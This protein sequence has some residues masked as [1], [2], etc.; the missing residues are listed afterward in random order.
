M[1]LFLQ[2]LLLLILS[3]SFAQPTGHQRLFLHIT[4]KA[5]TI[6]FEKCFENT[7]S[8]NQKTLDYKGYQ[9]NDISSNPTGFRYYPASGFIHK[10]FMD[11]N[12]RIQI[13]RHKTDTMNIEILNAFK[14]Y[15]L[16]IAFRPGNFR[17]AVNDGK[18]HSW[19][20]NTLPYKKLGTDEN[21][22]NITPPDWSVFSIASYKSY[23]DYFISLE[24]EK[25]RI[26]AKPI[27]P[28]DDPNFRNPRRINNLK[29]ETE[30]YNFDGQ[31]DYREQ[32]V[33]DLTSWN[34]FIY[35]GTEKGFVLDTL[36][37]SLEYCTFDFE[38]K[39][40]SGSKTTRVNPELTQTDSYKYLDGKL[41]LVSQLI[42]VHAF[43]HSEKKD[44][45]VFVLENGVMVFKELIHGAE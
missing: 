22:Y 27:I 26:L 7:A 12:H 25:Q 23:L 1:K 40:F 38:K 43:P 11:R 45:S 4:D 33:K 41:T 8:V 3:P 34:Y 10:T 2:I 35:T 42:C 32:K 37:S 14:V 29:I 6:H 24:F 28:E 39:T 13:V 44:C 36:L 17:L 18:E 20:Y 16:H 30:D 19:L 9:L 5:D 15:F 21:I 31:K